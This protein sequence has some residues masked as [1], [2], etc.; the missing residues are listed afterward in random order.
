MVGIIDDIASAIIKR[1][2]GKNKIEAIV[3]NPHEISEQFRKSL[4][5]SMKPAGIEISFAGIY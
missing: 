2:I 5:S 4:N 3:K 1:L